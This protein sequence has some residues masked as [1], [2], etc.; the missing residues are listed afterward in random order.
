MT[1]S[2]TDQ[3]LGI[4]T[5]PVC[6]TPTHASESDDYGRCAECAEADAHH[7]NRTEIKMT[8]T[9]SP[10]LAAG[11]LEGLH[12][13]DLRNIKRRVLALLAA[14]TLE[15]LHRSLPRHQRAAWEY[16]ADGEALI[17]PGGYLIT[18]TYATCELQLNTDRDGDPSWRYDFDTE[19]LQQAITAAKALRKARQES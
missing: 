6:H 12:I 16:D 9:N 19:G 8:T 14:G 3:D 2:Y 11:T 15:G 4:E 13:R 17:G 10:L 1:T 7:P 5:C 18:E